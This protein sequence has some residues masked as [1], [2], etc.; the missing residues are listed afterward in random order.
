[1]NEIAAEV[2]REMSARPSSEDPGHNPTSLAA[3]LNTLE[4]NR[5]SH[6]N[7]RE[8]RCQLVVATICAIA[9]WPGLGGLTSVACEKAREVIGALIEE[10]D[11]YR[12]GLLDCEAE[13]RRV[14]K[15]IRITK[16]IEVALEPDGSIPAG[17]EE[18]PQGHAAP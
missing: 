1:M 17:I 14:L 4:A 10:R 13:L 7:D 9:V 16:T 18:A 5:R 8:E 12:D 11:T 2:L 6:P 15:T 3:R